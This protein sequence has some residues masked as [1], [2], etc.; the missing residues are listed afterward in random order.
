MKSKKI[1]TLCFISLVLFLYIIYPKISNRLSNEYSFFSK[2]EYVFLLLILFSVYIFDIYDEIKNIKNKEYIV[3]NKINLILNL[4][5]IIIIIYSITT[6][7]FNLVLLLSIILIKD[8]I[9]Y[10]SRNK[11]E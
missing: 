10:I 1:I 7:N 4:V 11:Q 8:I 3:A 5:S 2:I 6:N 9:F